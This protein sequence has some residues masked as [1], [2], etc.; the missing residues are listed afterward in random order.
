MESLNLYSLDEKRPKIESFGIITQ[1]MDKSG[2]SVAW[3][4]NF[5]KLNSFNFRKT[6]RKHSLLMEDDKL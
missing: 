1:I 2:V 4:I 5:R 6:S 3:K